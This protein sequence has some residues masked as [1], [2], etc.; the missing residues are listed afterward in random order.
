[1]HLIPPAYE[2][3]ASS[4]SP[5]YVWWTPDHSAAGNPRYQHTSAL[6]KASLRPI[7]SLKRLST[8]HLCHATDSPLESS[9]EHLNE[10]I[11]GT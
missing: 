7:P 5:P 9:L 3:S 1:M 8:T 6:V 11:P 10:Y 2:S 4:A